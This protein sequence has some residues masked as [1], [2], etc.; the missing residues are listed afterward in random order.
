MMRVNV[1]GLDAALGGEVT[2]SQ[3]F[4]DIRNSNVIDVV[5]LANSQHE[6]QRYL[7]TCSI[8]ARD[9][10]VLSRA[11]T[12]AG[13]VVLGRRVVQGVLDDAQARQN[14]LAAQASQQHANLFALATARAN[15]SMDVLDEIEDA[16]LNLVAAGSR[17]VDAYGAL[18]ARWGKAM[19][20]T[21][22]VLELP[23]VAGPT[24]P[25]LTKKIVPGV[26][27]LSAAL[28]AAPVLVRAGGSSDLIEHIKSRMEPPE[29]AAYAR[30]TSDSGLAGVA[31]APVSVG[32]RTKA[33]WSSK[34]QTL[35][36]RTF[37]RG[38]TPFAVP[39]HD[40]VIKAVRSD[41][42][43]RFLVGD[44]KSNSFEKYKRDDLAAYLAKYDIDMP[45]DPFA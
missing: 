1:L 2:S 31:G 21:A 43:Q 7:S 30:A 38:A 37:A 42:E 9:Q 45:F 16:A 12:L 8:A 34:M 22:A 27:G 17:D 15:K 36:A 13:L 41:G 19:Q 6:E 18:V 14:A 10:E 28:M 23:D 5:L 25:I 20:R 3:L 35:W 24:I 40:L 32:Q 11:G 26:W 4:S 39:G 29:P 33:D 44:P